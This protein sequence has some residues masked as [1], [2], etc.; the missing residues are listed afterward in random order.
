MQAIPKI[1]DLSLGIDVWELRADL[2]AS[3]DLTFLA[4]QIAI[5]RRHSPLPILFTIRTVKHGGR[6]PN[7]ET[8]I[9]NL[10]ALLIH[11]LRLGVEYIDVEV[12]FPSSVLEDVVSSKGNTTVIGSYCDITGSISWTGPQTKQVYDKIVQMGADIIKIVNVAR[13]FED[14]LS[15][16][17]FV[18]TVERNPKPILA[19]NLGPE[20]SLLLF[21]LKRKTTLTLCRARYHECSTMFCRLFHIHC[22]RGYLHPDKYRFTRHRQFSISRAFFH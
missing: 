17:Q 11:A 18:A 6:F 21:L 10:H 9:N 16:R 19:I 3:L 20:A 5:L 22:C 12:T 15:L 1:E 4:F 8:A 7:D 2:L 14:N 13:S